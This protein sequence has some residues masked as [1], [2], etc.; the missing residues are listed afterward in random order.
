M[1]NPT[2]SILMNCYNGEAF[3]RSS[4]QSVLEQTFKDWELIFFDNQ[5]TDK[6]AKIFKSFND[7][8]LVYVRAEKHTGLGGARAA[9]FKFLKGKYI[10]ILDADDLWLP[11]K[12]ERQIPFF[13]DHEVGIVICNTIFFS[14]NREKTLYN[15]RPPPSGWVTGKLLENYFVSLET[16]VFR[17]SLI[18]SLGVAFDPDFNFISD[19]DLVVRLSTVSKLAYCPEILAKW[20]IHNQSDTWKN[21]DAFSNEKERWM[22]KYLNSTNSFFERDLA[23][24]NTFCSKVFCHQAIFS[25]LSRQRYKA[26]KLLLKSNFK[27]FLSW[28]VLLLL[29]A[30]FASTA[31]VIAIKLKKRL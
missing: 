21:L 22:N 1:N 4:V 5:S 30:P 8:R 6:S 17:K 9:A 2:V 15:R 10:A 19:F 23:E 25:I 20:R 24:V 31:I 29:F 3:L 28:L 13:D 16:L 12:L 7:S 27:D 18:D 26:L 11:E 14:G